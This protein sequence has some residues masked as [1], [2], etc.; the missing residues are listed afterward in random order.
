MTKSIQERQEAEHQ[1]RVVKA[2]GYI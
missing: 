1:L 2:H